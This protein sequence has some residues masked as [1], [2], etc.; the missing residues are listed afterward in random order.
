MATPYLCP[1]CRTNRT[2]F[3][4]I[5]QVPQYVKLDPDTGNTVEL[6]DA[7]SID[8]LHIPYKGSLRRVQCGVCG[9]LDDEQ[10]F[11]ATARNHPRGR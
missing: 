8:P 3:A 4:V 5:E 2:K 7:A 6:L 11:A 1:A 10:T 9:L